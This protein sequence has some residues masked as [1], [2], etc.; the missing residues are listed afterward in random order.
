VRR[1]P[2]EATHVAVLP[3]QDRT[4]FRGAGVLLPLIPA[5]YAALL[6]AFGGNLRPE[7]IAA[8]VACI[9]LGFWS[10][11]SAA[12]YRNLLP[13]VL[14]GVGYDFVRYPRALWVTADRVL[15]CGLRDAE[16]VLFSAAPGVSFPAWFGAH[17]VPALDLLA[18]VPYASFTYL[19]FGYAVWLW[20]RDRARM[21]WFLWSFAIANVISFVTW[22]VLPAAPPWYIQTHGCSIDM[23]TLPSPA[24][25]ARVDRLLGIEYF[26]GFYSRAASVFGALPSMHCAYPM[27]GLLT[28][29]NHEPRRAL[30]LHLVYA[31]WMA[32]AAVYLEHHWVL[33]VLA[34]WATAAAGVVLARLLLAPPAETASAGSATTTTEG[35]VEG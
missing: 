32:L 4:V 1:T 5:I 9:A 28:A 31:A 14:T 33:D 15:G 2:S 7:H 30:A 34:G 18:A 27:L 23:N 13:F 6:F 20:F 22:I 26:S 35:V 16:L 24:G 21:R 25:L 12:L 3:F 19:A 29:W 8:G 10:A 11:K 17:A